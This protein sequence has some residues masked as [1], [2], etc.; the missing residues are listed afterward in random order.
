MESTNNII[1]NSSINKKSVN[2]NSSLNINF[3]GNKKLL[4][5][6]SISD[7]INS[8]DVYIN[9]RE[10][11]NKFRLVI[12][13]NPFCSNVLF[14]PFT[15]I[16]KNEGSDNAICLNYING[17]TE[18][19]TIGKENSFNW[20]Q[21]EAIRDTQL[22]N[23]NCGFDYHCGIDIFNNHILRNKTSKSVNYSSDRSSLP[24]ANL[25]DVY[26]DSYSGCCVHGGNIQ[27]EHVYDGRDNFNTIDDYQRDRWGVI[28]SDEFIKSVDNNG[29]FSSITMPLHLYQNDDA[30]S[31][32]ECV[33]EKLID[34][35]GW[36]GFI[37]PST[38]SIVTIN[39]ENNGHLINRT[40]NNKEEGAFIEMYPG[41]DLFSFVPKYNENRR[42]LEYNWKYCITYPSRNAITYGDDN[43]EFPFLRIDSSGNT[44]LKVYM[45]DEGTV[46]DDGSN[47]LTIYSVSQHGLMEGDTIN[48]YKGNNIFY[49]SVEVKNVVDKYIFQVYKSTSNMSDYWIEVEDR[50]VDTIIENP[51]TYNYDDAQLPEERICGGVIK[52]DDKYYPICE[53]NR[54]NVDPN[55]QDIHFRRV[56]NGVECKYYVRMFS[57]LPNFKFK[58]GE[59]NDFTLY[60]NGNELLR[61]FSDPQRDISNFESHI[62]KLGFANTAYGDDSVEIVFTDDIDTSYLK[63]NLGR[64]LSEIYLTIVKNNKGYKEWYGINRD[65]NIN[66]SIVE[67]SHCFGEINDSFVLSN[68][69]REMYN[70]ANNN[71]ALHDVR[72]LT[73]SSNSKKLTKEIDI[74]NN[75]EYY[76]D[77]CCYSPVDCDEQSIQMSMHRFNTVQRE[78]FNFN[79]SQEIKNTFS[80]IYYDELQDDENNHIAESDYNFG[81]PYNF[82]INGTLKHSVKKEFKNMLEFQEGYYYQP[83][84]RIQ[85]KT[86][87]KSISDYKGIQFV[88]YAID[89]LGSGMVSFKTVVDNDFSINEKAVLYK[90]STNEYYNII[91]KKIQSSSRF[92]CIIADENGK[93]IDNISEAINGI[94]DINKI[95]DFI[96]V[97]ADGSVPSYANIIKDGSCRF[98]WR[99]VVSNG[100]EDDFKV[101]PFT[102]GA[103]YVQKQINFFLRRQDPHADNLYCVTSEFNYT[104]NGSSIT[105]Y[106]NFNLADETNY[107]ANEIKEC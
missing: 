63:D 30:L 17:Y 31:Y 89:D 88:I 60:G 52:V 42:R 46:D 34:K 94:F 39:N 18:E 64:P 54:C 23:E 67:Y 35:N 95:D 11:S 47:I 61:K 79:V 92:D 105:D 22:S 3:S 24:I 45:F 74:E 12:N 1:L 14:N 28:V 102:N 7:I 93:E 4:P 99:N 66:D 103:F 32:R 36:Y 77:L 41:S 2:S 20:N 98:Y 50:N 58:D 104:P 71:I 78:L 70:N 76:G 49:D 84:Y 80:S 44:S 56:V 85:I 82:F 26:G 106:D 40:I 87:S 69:Y 25:C 37:N 8:Y 43:R 16:V 19:N 73:Y 15:E 62:S 59:I 6:D 38:T 75:F 65:I 13:L 21:Y 33:S 29:A 96:I 51:F 5:E 55:A 107:K 57:R 83:H 68:Y 86:V 97:K 53:S 91:A 9:E 72:D 48:I 81:D 10:K 100:V 27:S 101:Y 90:K